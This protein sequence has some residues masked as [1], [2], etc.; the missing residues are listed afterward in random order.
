[1]ILPP[2]AT[3]KNVAHHPSTRHCWC[4]DR[5]LLS[6][7]LYSQKAVH[8]EAHCNSLSWDR[9]HQNC[10][11]FNALGGSPSPRVD[12]DWGVD[13]CPVPLAPGWGSPELCVLHR[14]PDFPQQNQSP[15]PHMIP[16]RV[17]SL[18]IGCLFFS[19]SFPPHH[20]CFLES[21]LQ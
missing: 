20:L 12:G 18:F 19:V 4:P 6:T 7:H 2:Q 14:L 21:L 15:V 5:I 3:Q 16:C 9:E 17:L 1:M 8:S 10:S 11:S 13:R